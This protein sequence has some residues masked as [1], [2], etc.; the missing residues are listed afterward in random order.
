MGKKRKSAYACFDDSADKAESVEMISLRKRVKKYY[1]DAGEIDYSMDY[2]D[3][4]TPIII[5]DLW[6]IWKSP[7][8]NHNKANLLDR[9]LEPMGLFELGL[10]TNVCTF[11]HEKYPGVVFKIALDRCGISDNIND[12]WICKRVP[13]VNAPQ[14]IQWEDTGIITVQ[15]FVYAIHR[16]EEMDLY[17]KEALEMCDRVSKNYLCIDLTP[18]LKENFAI[19]KDMKLRTCDASD[20]FPLNPEKDLMRCPKIVG[21]DKKHKLIR[22]NGKVTYDENFQWCYCNKCGEK[23]LPSQLRPKFERPDD[24][25]WISTGL[26]DVEMEY[27]SMRSHR[28][29][30]WK[31]EAAK[32][33]LKAIW[34][35]C[36]IFTRMPIYKCIPMTEVEI[37]KYEKKNGVK[38][39]P[40]TSDEPFIPDL[41]EELDDS[42]VDYEKLKKHSSSQYILP[43][44]NMNDDEDDEAEE[45][46]DDEVD[47]DE[48]WTND[49]GKIEFKSD[50]AQIRY[51]RKTVT[52]KAFAE[53]LQK[54]YRDNEVEIIRLFNKYFPDSNIEYFIPLNHDDRIESIALEDEDSTRHSGLVEYR[55]QPRVPKQ[56]EPELYIGS[57]DPDYI[58]SVPLTD[59]CEGGENKGDSN[60]IES[61]NIN[62]QE[63]EMNTSVVSTSDGSHGSDDRINTYDSTVLAKSDDKSS[64]AEP[65]EILV[66]EYT[67]ESS[68]I[69]IQLTD[70]PQCINIAIEEDKV[71]SIARLFAQRGPSI[72]LSVDGGSTYDELISPAML[73]S[74]IAAALEE[75]RG[76]LK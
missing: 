42:N 28:Y 40:Y 15:E 5:G 49:E 30:Y 19:G 62:P 44:N 45:T 66:S 56:S 16:Q 13:E 76:D 25:F 58:E 8:S 21:E 46:F 18:K 4:C 65:D 74:I 54:T 70:D 43:S 52:P 10:G 23:L 26:S 67:I 60:A 6:T 71:Y 29:Q 75:V 63:S 35:A 61:S 38:I 72:Y 1:K 37:A 68:D 47:E 27:Y 14:V 9:L 3:W 33:G 53:H 22:C 11:I 36:P 41:P 55:L 34:E 51:I 50:E 57:H 64:S 73:G 32:R 31:A 7:I 2:L 59:E 48:Y 24:S 20:L 17:W 12:R 39:I 69:D